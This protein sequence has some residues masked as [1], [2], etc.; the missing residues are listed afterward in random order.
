[1]SRSVGICN[2]STTE[3]FPVYVLR[4]DLKEFVEGK[5][6][7]NPC[8]AVARHSAHTRARG[9]TTKTRRGPAGDHQSPLDG[10]RATDGG[11]SGG[12]P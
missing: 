3:D 5:G 11:W 10:R 9:T 6:C 1:M 8:V 2:R 12:H 7:T 4:R